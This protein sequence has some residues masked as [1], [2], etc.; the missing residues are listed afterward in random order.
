[1]FFR[2]VAPL[3]ADSC[4][5]VECESG[6]VPLFRLSCWHVVIRAYMTLIVSDAFAGLIHERGEWATSRVCFKCD[7]A[8]EQQF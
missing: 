2:L 3:H 4:T 8:C 7:S 6:W 5:Y 1:M